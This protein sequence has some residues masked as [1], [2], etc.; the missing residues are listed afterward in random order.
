MSAL[1]LVLIWRAWEQLRW[2][3]GKFTG[4]EGGRECE[5]RRKCVP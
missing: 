4:G 1:V 5:E 2:G 3:E